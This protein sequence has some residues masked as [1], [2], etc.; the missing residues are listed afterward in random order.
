MRLYLVLVLLFTATLESKAQLQ[1]NNLDE[2]LQYADS[3]APASLQAKILP[4]MAKQD[5]RVQASGL[6]PK[7]NVFGT[8]DYYPIIAT[9]VIPAEVLGGKPG[10]YLK[11]Q[12]GLPYIFTSGAE[13]SMPLIS[14][15]KWAQVA[16]ARASYRQSEWSYKAGMELFHIQLIQTYYQALISKEV[17]KLNQENTETATE[18]SRIMEARY[19][20]GVVN[21]SDY[22]RTIN[23]NLDVQ[24]SG[25]NAS[26][27]VQLSHIALDSLLH[28]KDSIAVTEDITAFT[29]PLLTE[30]GNPAERAGWKEAD[31]KLQVAQYALR[32]SKD[33]VLPK[34]ALAGRYAY[35]FQSKFNNTGNVQFDVANI[36]ARLDFPLFQGNYY[37][38]AR[39]KSKLQYELT[40]IDI[41]KTRDM[42]TQQQQAWYD[43]YNAAFMK[44]NLM[45]EKVKNAS[46]NLRIAKLNLKEGVMEFDEFNNIYI[47]YNRAK[48]DYLQN[49]ADGIL[50]YL[51]STQKF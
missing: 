31:Y 32:A 38:S 35:N 26:K 29:W 49:L 6:Y 9:Q 20:N 13:I 23:L 12:F 51:L 15:D 24:V 19:K 17:L 27:Q 28:T 4:K 7:I 34:I 47:E 8:A 41:D 48:I 37:R 5:M 10:T 40:K 39:N 11:A 46:E 18:L 22:N 50:Y 36:G 43:Q 42:L 45:K 16:K 1:L 21:P 44:Q 30:A 14:F 25:I 2:L 3:H 33:S